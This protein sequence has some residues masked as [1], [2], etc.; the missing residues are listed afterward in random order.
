MA[1]QRDNI[2]FNTRAI[3]GYQK[4]INVLI[5]A[6]EPGKTT[7]LWMDEIYTPW[8]KNHFPWIILVRQCVEISD[9]YISSIFSNN[10]NKFT[11][12][13]V[14]P[15]YKPS[16][17]QS[18]CLDIFI[19]NKLFVRII[20]LSMKL[21]RLKELTIP[22]CAGILFDEYI[23]DPRVQE[24]Y[25]PGEYTK[26]ME[27]YNSWKRGKAPGIK[28]LKLWILGNPYSLFNPFFVGQGVEVAKLKRGEFYVKGD[29]VIQWIVLNP[30]LREKMLEENPFYEFDE[31]YKGYALDGNTKNDKNIKLGTLPRNFSIQFI[32]KVENKYIAI[33]KNSFYNEFEDKYYCDFIKDIS[34]YRTIYCFDFCEMVDKSILISI[35]ERMKLARF[36]NAIRMREVIYSNINVY[37]F[38]E[39][40]YQNL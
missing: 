31:D 28:R 40:V 30:K 24:K 13:N 39:G 27:G 11:D 14:K 5:S 21:K 26:I 25:L 3:N 2:H 6:R 29:M 9:E 12:D 38:I 7:S 4:S 32:F 16:K 8:K 22:N 35:E 34:K 33:Y 15:F 18:G 17:M 23:I 10:M 37:Y 36:K 1:V 20:A 19:D